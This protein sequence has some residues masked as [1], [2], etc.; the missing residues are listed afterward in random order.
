MMRELDYAFLYRV[1][2]THIYTLGVTEH[3]QTSTNHQK[4]RAR[5]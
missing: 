2:Q 5:N 1:F 3:I 4:M